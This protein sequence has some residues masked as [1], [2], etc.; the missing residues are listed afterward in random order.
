MEV[1]CKHDEVVWLLHFCGVQIDYHVLESCVCQA[2]WNFL[3]QSPW[4]D[5]ILC[6]VVRCKHKEVV[7][8]ANS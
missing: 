8:T 5:N 3:L 4:V 6:H 7:T 2:T 1:V